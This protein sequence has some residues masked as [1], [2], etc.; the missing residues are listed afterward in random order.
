MILR[1]KKS[2]PSVIFK[3]IKV[4]FRPRVDGD[5]ED[6]NDDIIF[7]IELIKQIEVNIDYILMLVA[8]YCESNRTDKEIL[9]AIDKAVNSSL[10]L[11]SKKEL[12]EGFIS[13]VNAS[14]HV[15]DDW[16]KFVAEQ[17]ETDLTALIA[18]ENLKEEET[19]RFINNSFRDGT[20]KTTGTDIDKILP[21]VSRFGDGSRQEKKRGVIAKLLGFFEKYLEL[22]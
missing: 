6:I 18:D 16:Q 17:K 3:V 15:D 4:E 2:C 1:E 13:R 7:E 8:K 9:A 11:R 20:L 22:V 19:R 14:A 21:P 12:I 5:K 10:E